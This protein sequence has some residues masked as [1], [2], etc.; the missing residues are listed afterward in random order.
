M[1]A[2]I[3]D[4]E[5][6]IVSVSMKWPDPVVARDWANQYVRSFNEF[7]RERTMN[8]VRRKQEYLEQEVLVTK[9]IVN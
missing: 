8:D 5:T 6:D 1:R 7:I 3:R 4:E 2:V 9:S